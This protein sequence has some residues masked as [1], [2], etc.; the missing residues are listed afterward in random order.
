MSQQ[1]SK[2]IPALVTLTVIL[3]GIGWLFYSS[4]GEAFEY[5]KHV[6]EITAKPLQQWEGKHL[7]VHG[8]VVPAIDHEADGQRAP[9]DRVQV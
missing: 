9:A 7:Q 3:G 4:A 5:Y 1:K 6:D 8:F 2:V